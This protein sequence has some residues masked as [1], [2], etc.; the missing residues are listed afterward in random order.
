M[1]QSLLSLTQDILSSMDADEVT[2]IT[3]TIESEQVA[4]IIKQSY[5][6]ILHSTGLTEHMGLFSLADADAD[7]PVLL[8]RPSDLLE[9]VTFQYNIRDNDS[10]SDDWRELIYLSPPEYME[11]LRGF[12]DI[13]VDSG[14]VVDSF[15]LDADGYQTLI[16]FR[17]DRHPTYWTSFDDQNIICDSFDSLVDTL[18]LVGTK[19]SCY[20]KLEPTWVHTDAFV[21]DLDTEQFRLLYNEAKATAWAEMKQTVHARA[22]KKV[23]TNK[24]HL[25]RKKQ[26]LPGGDVLF[27][28]SLPNYGR[29]R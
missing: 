21:P 28:R 6:D 29:R 10:V 15:E 17:T 19:T 7:S 24:I 22:E 4:T 1:K 3:D 5:F 20:G 14:L 11:Y 26:D 25:E 2:S 8:A 16:Q 23:R 9:L 12:P 13:T 27:R 18:G